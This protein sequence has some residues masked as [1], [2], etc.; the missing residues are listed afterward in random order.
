[1]LYFPLPSQKIWLNDTVLV[2]LVFLCS[3]SLPS[4]SHIS[5]KGYAGGTLHNWY[6]LGVN[7][8]KW[9][10]PPHSNKTFS[11]FLCISI[12][13]STF[14]KNWTLDWL[15]TP[16]KHFDIYK[17]SLDFSA[18][19]LLD[20]S[21]ALDTIDIVLLLKIFFFLAFHSNSFIS[22]AL[23]CFSCQILLL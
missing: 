2:T 20:F 9:F 16:N 1:M 3:V 19:H 6:P 14:L 8:W 11:F 10:N 5:T 17:P 13:I 21:A 15:L 18:S 23:L 4:L 12:L 7:W 22:L